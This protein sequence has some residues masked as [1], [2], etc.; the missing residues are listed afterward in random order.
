M[1]G[2]AGFTFLNSPGKLN[3]PKAPKKSLLFI[4]RLFHDQKND[5]NLFLD[6]IQS[7]NL[8]A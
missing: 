4:C 3:P 5:Y 7:L 2:S 6:T 8:I 1:T